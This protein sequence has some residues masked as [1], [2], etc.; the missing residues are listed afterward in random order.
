[1]ST[2]GLNKLV[3][4]EVPVLSLGAYSVGDSLGVLLVVSDALKDGTHSGRLLEI[5]VADGD[6][7]K[8]AIDFVFYDA[9]VTSGTDNAAYAPT[10]ATLKSS[11]GVVKVAAADYTTYGTE[12]VARVS[13]ELDVV[14]NNTLN[15][16]VQPVVQGTPTYTAA[17][18]LQFRFVIDRD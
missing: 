17:S 11:V 12:A 13:V 10:Y 16:Y 2:R 14:L 3:F 6:N 15:L 5:V 7:Q 4:D 18:N 1:M 9:A 8:A